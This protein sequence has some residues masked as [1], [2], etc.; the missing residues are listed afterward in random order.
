[1]GLYPLVQIVVIPVITAPLTYWAGR[2]IQGKAGWVTFAILAYT[3]LLMTT[4]G[5]AI[6]GGNSSY[7]EEFIWAPS[8]NLKFG[9]L[10]DGLNLPILLTIGS[11]CTIIA[12][13]SMTYM[14]HSIGESPSGYASYFSLYQLYAAGMMGTVL[15]TNLIE[16]YLFFE[17]MLV[18]S[19]ALINSFGTGDRERIALMYFMWTHVG[20]VCLLAGILTAYAKLGSFEIASLKLL[21]GDPIAPWIAVAMLIGFFTKMAVFGLHVWLPYAHAEAPTPISALLSPAMIGI[22][23]YAT[24]RIVVSSFTSTFFAMGDVLS[25]WALVTII[26]GGMMALAQDDIKRLLA[27]SSI[28]QMGYLLLGISSSTEMGMAG[29]LFHY[30]S[31]ATCKGILFLSAGIL[32][33]QLEGTR[34]IRKLGGLAAKMPI[35]AMAFILGFLGIAGAPPLNGFQ[36]EWM[37]FSGAFTG[38]IHSSPLR[39][40]IATLSLIS[41]VITAGYALWAI[42][43][44]FFGPLPDNLKMAKEA[45]ITMTGPLIVLAVASIILGIYPR[46]V[47]D[48][49]I[50]AISHI[51]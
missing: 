43:R 19:W 45:P 25:I 14:H 35:T 24:V 3:T 17:L 30:V 11:L 39:L 22:G 10:L 18:P 49:I 1:M 41:T 40:I 27:Y 20:A 47:T 12:V 9:L 44:I 15:A 38:A 21:A 46:L 2:R 48:Y 5:W 26:Y 36:S 34:S 16:F 23:A 8:L 4:L 29:S 33:Y 32:I 7:R 37:I 28:S 13:Y 50:P 51:V 6:Y 31:H 42:R